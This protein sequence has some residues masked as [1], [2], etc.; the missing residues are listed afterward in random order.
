MRV[1]FRQGTVANAVVSTYSMGTSNISG[2][3]VNLSVPNPNFPVTYHFAD[4]NRNYLHAFRLT[5]A[6]AWGPFL[7]GIDAYLYVDINTSTGA[8]SFG[9]SAFDPVV[10]VTAPPSPAQDQ[11][12]FDMLNKQMKVW[13]SVAMQWVRKVRVFVGKLSLGALPLVSMSINAGLSNSNASYYLGTTIGDQSPNSAGFILFNNNGDVLRR[14]DGTFITTEDTLIAEGVQESAPITFATNTLAAVASASLSAYTMVAFSAPGEVSAMTDLDVNSKVYGIIVE[15]VAMGGTVTVVTQGIVNN[16][17]WSWPTVNAPLYVDGT[18]QLTTTRPASAPDPVAAVVDEFTIYLLACDVNVPSD[19]FDITYVNTA[20]DTMT[21]SLIM[22]GAGTQVV[23]TNAPT[24]G[25]HAVNKTYSDAQLAAHAADF[26]LHVTANQNGMLD[27]LEAGGNGI[28]VKNA[29][30]TTVTRSLVA[31]AAGLTI[32][33]PDGVVDNPTFALANDL[34]ALEG[35]GTFGFATR[36]GVDT[37]LTRTMTGTAGNIVVTNGDGV[38][39]V[40]TFDLAPI[41]Q[42]VGGTLS[43]VTLDGFGRVTQNTPVVVADITALVDGTY[44]NVTG[45]TM[46]GNLAMGGFKVTGLANGTVSGDALHFGQ[47]GAQV[48]GWDAD[49]DAVAALASTGLM[50]RTGAGTAAT[51]SLVTAS[52]ARITVADGDGVAANPTVDLALLADA[53]TGTFLKITRDAWGRVSGT[54]PVLAADVTG[55]ISATYVDTAGDTMTGALLHP[56]GTAAAPSISFSGGVGHTNKGWYNSGVDEFSAA[57]AGAQKVLIDAAGV[58]TFSGFIQG[59]PGSLALESAVNAP[60]MVGVNFLLPGTMD[61]FIGG[62]P[63]ATFGP[64]PTFTIGGSVALTAADLGVTVQDWSATLDAVTAGTYTGAASIT[65]VGTIT[66]GVWDGTDVAVTAGGTGASTAAGARTNLGVGTGDSPEFLAVNIGHA[67]D[68]TIT[69]VSAGVIAVEGSN[70]LLASGLGSITQAWDAGL[71]E[72]AALATNG[73]IRRTGGAF[74]VGSPTLDE[75]TNAAASASRSHGNNTIEWEWS[76][77][78][79]GPTFWFDEAAAATGGS[80]LNQP[81]VLVRT[82]AGS[83]AAPFAVLSTEGSASYLMAVA[84]V[85]TTTGYDLR[86]RSGDHTTGHAG[87]VTV[88][89]G[90]GIAAAS[91]GGNVTLTAGTGTTTGAGGDI[92]ITAGATGTSGLAGDIVVTAGAGGTTGTAGVITISGGAGGTTTG[93]GGN[94]RMQGGA[95]TSGDTGNVVAGRGTTTTTRNGDFLQIPTVSGAPTGTPVN[96]SGMVSIVFRTDT[97]QIYVYDGAWLSTAALT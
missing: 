91:N 21:G 95:F 36:T 27:T 2:F 58:T 48:Q 86:L 94:V 96:E 7:P 24:L 22:T 40:P 25:S 9:S 35:L 32:T 78:S 61:V 5:R 66:T 29:T 12:W 33:N 74:V 8:I 84:R 75:V 62:A 72:L 65:T 97:N 37:W 39:G 42:G 63:I 11:H 30:A 46:S 41:V 87:N 68:T 56:A 10:A 16:P 45:D 92:S 31:P 70:V 81:L 64:G 59:A 52:S 38:S 83:T 15:S 44:V 4:G 18:G 93:N 26:T 23:L 1:T 14:S 67:S 60:G 73:P 76:R 71:D 54:T 43:K 3:F 55:L 85:A 80:D 20:G 82:L 57:I 90:S 13:D 88:T 47:I 77:T 28:V 19:I 79:I 49:L 50:V 53:G 17:L 34:A 6:D 51:R 89:G 69:R